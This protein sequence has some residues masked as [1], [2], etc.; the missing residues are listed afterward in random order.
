LYVAYPG[1]LYS[2]EGLIKPT[3][4]GFSNSPEIPLGQQNSGFLDQRLALNWTQ[5][6]IQYFGGNP[7]NVTVFSESAGAWSAKQLLAI[8]PSPLPFQAAIIESEALALP[9]N[10]TANYQNV[11]YHFNCTDISCLRNVSMNS[12]QDYISEN[13][14]LFKPVADNA[15]CVSDIRNSINNGTFANVSIIIGTNKNELSQLV[16]KI[17]GNGTYNVDQTLHVICDL[18]HQK[19]LPCDLFIKQLQTL[20]GS[21]NLTWPDISRYDHFVIS[22]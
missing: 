7:S 18:L 2:I 20:V 13:N 17:S 19:T 22:L 21:R 1:F 12:I 11:S 10:G 5:K 3:V 16:Y 9:G 6:N 4:F 8:P 14:L 15:T